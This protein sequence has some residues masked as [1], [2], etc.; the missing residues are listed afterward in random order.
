M[1]FPDKEKAAREAFR[2]LKPGGTFLFSVW[3]AIEQN[4]LPHTAH[5]V[6]AK[7]FADNPP[8]FY[9]VPFSFHDPE[10][11]GS[12]L[13]AVG[14][15]QIELTLLP[16]AAIAASAADVEKGRFYGNT[17]INA[18]KERDE[19]RIPEIEA[20]LTDAIA[21]AFGAAPVRARMQALICAAN[22]PRAF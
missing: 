7:F 17:I 3:D 11:I 16:L 4:D 14:F 6:V 1:F 15:D 8:D 20:A 21:G 9:D 2:V 10:R 13:S 22:R 5:A 19:S 12:L 18:I